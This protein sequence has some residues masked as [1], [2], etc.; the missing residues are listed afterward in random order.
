ML[1]SSSITHTEVINHVKDVERGI[2]SAYMA[3]IR[4]AGGSRSG[5]YG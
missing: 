1:S 4:S 2:T 5:G 3:R